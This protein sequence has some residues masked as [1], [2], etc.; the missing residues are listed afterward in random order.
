[1]TQ[2]IALSPADSAAVRERIARRCRVPVE[3]LTPQTH[4]IRD[5]HVDGASLGFLLALLESAM[6]VK[7]LP[8]L[9]KVQTHFR[10]D[11][12]GRLTP[13]A[14]EQLQ[15]LLPGIDLDAARPAV[16]D[17]LLT[18]ATI[19]AMV[20]R[21]LA[22]RPPGHTSERITDWQQQDWLRGLP[23]ELGPRKVRLLLAACCR[24]I[25]RTRPNPEPEVLQALDTLERFADT[26][27]GKTAL[28]NAQKGLRQWRLDRVPELKALD[29]SLSPAAPEAALSLAC[30]VMH[31]ANKIT[32]GEAL[33]RFKA[34]HRDLVSPL[35]DPAEFAAAWR[36]PAVI[37]LARSM[38]QSR[39]F[40]RMED[41]AEALQQAG[42]EQQSI[43]EHCRAKGAVHVR[44]CWLIDA[45][46][47]GGSSSG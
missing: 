17:D 20:A 16:V 15:Q 21:A 13:A 19:E 24:A 41:L 40:S 27:K 11:A 30:S 25:F 6:E 18:V 3:Q 39:D 35:K 26:G 1:M 44:G 42:C 14:R 8:S 7:L 36:T 4:L 43:L 10:V 9:K 34:F 47:D 23:A 31:H 32:E 29:E 22:E 38:Y 33:Q 12:D 2:P 37:A 45:I 28:L 46:L 5:L